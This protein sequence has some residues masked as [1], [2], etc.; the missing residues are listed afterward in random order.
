MVS[1]KETAPDG[2]KRIPVIAGAWEIM[3]GKPHL[4]GTQCGRCKEAFFPPREI[5]PFCL[6]DETITRAALGNTGRIYTATTI[7]M[8]SKE[9]SP[10]YPFAYVVLDKEG[11]RIPSQLT[12]IDDADNL[13]SGTPVEMVI[14]VLRRDDEGNEIMTFKFKP[15]TG[16]E[17]SCGM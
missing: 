6:T 10:P 15:I 11:I 4:I 7:R 2:V 5:C 13:A 17:Q 16:G 14:D 8:A 1:E 12:G 3:D 9:F